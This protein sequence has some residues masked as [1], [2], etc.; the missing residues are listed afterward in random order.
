MKRIFSLIVTL[1]VIYEIVIFTSGCAQM[2]PPTGGPRDTIPPVLLGAMPKD[3]TLNFT[4]KKIIL[5]FDEFINLDK[6]EQEVIVSPTPKTMPLMEAKLRN[7][8]ITI[9]DT[10]EENTTYSIDFGRSLKDL[11]EGNPFKNFTYLFSTG[12]YLDSGILS[13]KVVLAEN[14]KTDST[15]I[16]MLHKNFEDSAVAKEK[17]RYYTRL[18]SAGLFHF[19]HIA[20]GTYNI[21]ALKDAGGQKMYMNGADLFAFYGSS[22]V[23]A[24]TN[25][26]SPVL[27]AFIEAPEADRG[28]RPGGGGKSAG[29][30]KTPAKKEK[31]LTVQT[32]LEAGKQDLLSDLILTFS[33]SLVTFDETKLHFTDTLFAPVTGYSLEADTTGTKISFKY[34][35]KEGENFKLILEK[36]IASDSSG[37]GLAKADTISFETKKKEDYGALRLR[38]PNLDTTQNIV[39][40]LFKGDKLDKAQPATGKEIRFELFPPGD[41]EIRVLYD[42]NRNNK[43]DTGNYWEKIQPEKIVTIPKKNTIRPNWDNEITIELPENEPP[44]VLSR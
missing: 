7:V 32:N 1:L 42:R 23:V 36:D 19:S 12:S 17:P 9:K 26:V 28:G 4:G 35:W 21:Y 13:G 11:N 31:T 39:L 10:L 14:G 2:V 37:A 33:D 3:S 29:S 38:L 44:D 15:L 18:D 24:D 8:T 41:Y 27:Y 20:P 30:S 6:P 16:V 43:W 40:L 22:V 25:T 5:E 34:P